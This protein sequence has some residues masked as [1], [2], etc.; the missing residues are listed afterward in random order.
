MMFILSLRARPIASIAST[1][2]DYSHFGLEI[3]NEFGTKNSDK[4]P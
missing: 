3:N 4:H 1:D 2:T